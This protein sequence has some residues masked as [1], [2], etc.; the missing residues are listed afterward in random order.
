[1]VDV[2]YGHACLK[3][4]NFPLKKAVNVNFND[5]APAITRQKMV[6]TIE[7]C[8]MVVFT[9]RRYLAETI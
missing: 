6:E 1:M 7:T 3:A 8:P 5:A 2:Y 4:N 9:E